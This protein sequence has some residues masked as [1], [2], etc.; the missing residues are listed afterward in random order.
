MEKERGWLGQRI[1]KK[2]FGER[3]Q[4]TG[5]NSAFALEAPM[6]A[7]EGLSEIGVKVKSHCTACLSH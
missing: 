5:N 1:L 4:T 3:D 6:V 7:L 2:L